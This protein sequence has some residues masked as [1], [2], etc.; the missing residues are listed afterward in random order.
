MWLR[1]SHV[2]NTVRQVISLICLILLDFGSRHPRPNQ[3][4]FSFPDAVSR[5]TK[6]PG[7]NFREADWPAIRDR[8]K[9]L[10][11]EK[12]P[13]SR[14]KTEDEFND[15]VSSFT[16]IITEVL[17]YE[18]PIT[19]PSPFSR[20]WW[21]KELT[22]LKRKQNRLS[23]KSYK[24]RLILDQP[25]HA[26][27]K[28][29]VREFRDTLTSTRN[30]HWTDWL[31]SAVQ[32]DIY[33]A[34]KYMVAKPTDFSSVRVPT[35]KCSYNGVESLAEDNASKA[36][37]LASSFFP[38]APATSAVPPNVTYPRPLKGTKYFSRERIRQVF[39]SLSPYKAPGPDGIP[40]VVYIKCL[41]VLIDHLYFIYRAA[42]ELHIYHQSWRESLTCHEYPS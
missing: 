22:Q 12:L 2:Q 14:I 18:I 25:S 29:A 38:P 3:G 32:Q 11:D 5:S 39:K 13:A 4:N 34:N 24:F 21:T 40:N 37:A 15:T 30:Q 27:Y 17:N 28:A 6:Q 20:R 33:I 16:D 31:E 35:L 1:Q 9:L 7:R 26:E 19:E 8:L 10:L 36:K 41:D 23:N 42:M